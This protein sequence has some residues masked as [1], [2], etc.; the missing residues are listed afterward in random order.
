MDEC[1]FREGSDEKDKNNRGGEGRR[2]RVGARGAER[3][4]GRKR[5]KESKRGAGW[6]WRGDQEEDL[7]SV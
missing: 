7:E 3:E 1:R 2:A 5:V 4:K 6:A